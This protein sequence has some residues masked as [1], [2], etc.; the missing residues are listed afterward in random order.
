MLHCYPVPGLRP[1]R[2]LRLAVVTRNKYDVVIRVTFPSPRECKQP[3][4]DLAYQFA[5][6]SQA[7][8]H[9]VLWDSLSDTK[10]YPGFPYWTEVV[11]NGTIL[12][13][14][15]SEP[16]TGKIF[17]GEGRRFILVTYNLYDHGC[18]HYDCR[19]DQV[20]FQNV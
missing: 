19:Y 3:R 4:F 17:T 5:N 15:N 7:T 9:A 18:V 11:F 20:H 16:V 14:R 2:N 8:H 1:I 13:S 12:C 6:L 10:E